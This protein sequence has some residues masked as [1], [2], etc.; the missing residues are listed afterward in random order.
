MVALDLRSQW[1]Q[2][3]TATTK[4]W[5]VAWNS[6]PVDDDLPIYWC[7]SKVMLVHFEKLFDLVIE[8]ADLIGGSNIWLYM[9]SSLT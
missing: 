8:L 5:S 6:W 2:L 7:Q 9:A 1:E 4:V 3:L